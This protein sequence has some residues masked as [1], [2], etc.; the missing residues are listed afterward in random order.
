MEG[1]FCFRPLNQ[2]RSGCPCQPHWTF[3]LNACTRSL[4]LSQLVIRFYLLCDLASLLLLS[5]STLCDFHSLFHYAMFA[6]FALAL[7]SLAAADI[8]PIAPGPGDVF[9]AGAECTIK[10]TPDASASWTN[11]TISK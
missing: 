10:W 9:N 4:T 6:L 3:S 1:I 2:I 8:V 7:V 11:M 5:N